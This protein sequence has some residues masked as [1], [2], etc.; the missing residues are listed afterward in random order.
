MPTTLKQLLTI[1]R[2]LF[3]AVAILFLI[4]AGFKSRAVFEQTVLHAQLLP[5]VITI[6]LCASLHPLT[7]L[8]S[9]M[10]LRVAGTT[11]P[12]RTVLQIHVQ[13]LP[14]RYLPG[15]IWQTVS[16]MVDLHGLGVRRPQLST[17][18]VV[19]NVVPLAVAVVQG[20]LC[21]YLSGADAQLSLLAIILSGLL[22]LGCLPIALRHRYLLGGFITLKRYLGIIATVGAFWVTAS[23]AFACY[24][25]ALPTAHLGGPL[26][27]IF[28]AYQ[29]AWAAGF[30][31]IFAPQGLGV[32]ESVAGLLLRGALTLSE[33]AVLVA[34]FRAVVLAGDFL[35]YGILQLIRYRWRPAT[36]HDH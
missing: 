26:L 2:W 12:Y 6:A 35:A 15:G 31:A 28:G 27:R 1:S 30:A 7:A 21:L 10:V 24:W 32:F 20:G 5:I 34:G 29:L 11:I 16:R 14:A 23:T 19:E 4:V 13:R 33:I 22:V 9:W 8:F 3:S 17:L 36:S 18:I 25:S